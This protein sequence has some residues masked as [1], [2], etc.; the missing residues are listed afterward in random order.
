MQGLNLRQPAHGRIFLLNIG[1][2]RGGIALRRNLYRHR[3]RQRQPVGLV[4]RQPGGFKQTAPRLRQIRALP[5]CQ[6]WQTFTLRQ[7]LRC[8][9]AV[10]WL[11]QCLYLCM[12]RLIAEYQHRAGAVISIRQMQA[13]ERHRRALCRAGN[14][15]GVSAVEPGSF[16]RLPQPAQHLRP[17]E[18]RTGRRELQV[19]VKV[20]KARQRLVM[21][22]RL[23]Q[24][25]AGI[26]RD[27]DPF[28]WLNPRRLMQQ[29]AERGRHRAPARPLRR[30]VVPTMSVRRTLVSHRRVT[31]CQRAR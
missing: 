23:R 20:Q 18:A 29:A 13:V 30:P 28:A 9:R 12:E 19:R 26:R 1:V 25:M 21:F 31:L 16:L 2:K 27:T 10:S 7:C 3:G 8:V 15:Q 5:L 6:F 24:I 17:G 14:W 22:D 11:T 4:R